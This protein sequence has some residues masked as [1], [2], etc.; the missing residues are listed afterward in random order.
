MSGR[1]VAKVITSYAA[2]MVATSVAWVPLEAAAHWILS[3]AVGVDDLADAIG[4]GAM[5]GYAFRAGIGFH[6][7]ALREGDA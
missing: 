5:F 3:G 7:R 6:R 4:D 1:G 2:W